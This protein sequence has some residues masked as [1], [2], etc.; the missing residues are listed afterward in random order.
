MI[1][2]RTT[3]L[4]PRDRDAAVAAMAS[5]A[6]MS[7]AIGGG[8]MVLA[9]LARAAAV[10]RCLVD[11]SRA[12]LSSIAIGP[13]E[14]TLGAMVSYAQ[15]IASAEA[16][17]R[18]PLLASAARG[19]TGGASIRGQGTI[20][21]SACYANPGSDMPACLV[22]LDA[23]LVLA[24]VAGVR[25]V[26]AADFF[27]GAFATLREPNELLLELV[28]P[29]P[30]AERPAWG[31]EKL[32]LSEGSWPIATAACTLATGGAGELA[33][34]VVV[35]GGVA[36]TPVVLD[37]T[38]ALD[39]DDASGAV[40]TAA[41]VAIDEPWDDVLAPGA[42]RRDVAGAVAWRAVRQALARAEGGDGAG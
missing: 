16:S 15:L 35:L 13:E 39:C 14:V 27:V 19:I 22:A 6:T 17:A 33:G 34:A 29:A 11:L 32:K 40:A 12:G 4:A 23:R 9:E 24:S 1:R 5:A 7:V 28:L 30:A 20:G 21:G 10:P 26:A 18:L 38:D 25:E 2:G 36:A 42:Y 8:T 41:R 37:V 3:Y 31:Y